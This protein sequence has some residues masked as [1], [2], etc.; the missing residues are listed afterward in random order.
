[1]FP[2]R[3]LPPSGG[4]PETEIVKVSFLPGSPLSVT[5]TV[6]VHGAPLLVHVPLKVAVLAA[7][8]SEVNVTLCTFELVAW[9][10]YCRFPPIGPAVDRACTMKQKFPMPPATSIVPPP[11]TLPTVGRGGGS[12]ASVIF[13][14][15]ASLL[16]P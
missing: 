9:L 6:N 2:L 4:P 12:T 16:P 5:F 14:T 10:W 3:S 7:I 15:K 8:T 13:A 11:V 1:M